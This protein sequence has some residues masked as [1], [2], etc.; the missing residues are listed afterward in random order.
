[1]QGQYKTPKTREEQA[2]N[3]AIRS[4]IA[5]KNY[6]YRD[7]KAVKR[8]PNQTGQSGS[9]Q[10]SRS[11]EAEDRIEKTPKRGLINRIFGKLSKKEQKQA[12]EMSCYPIK[13]PKNFA[14][15]VLDLELLIDS[16]NF[17][18]HTVDELLKLY[19]VS[20]LS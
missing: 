12:K 1:M 9:G 16:G 17:D 13:L 5:T 4:D 20:L 11:Q 15:Q 2:D 18:I 6:N 19:S 10:R 7:K 8:S 14:N 3:E